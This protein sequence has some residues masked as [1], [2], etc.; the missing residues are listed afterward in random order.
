M[1]SQDARKRGPRD[2]SSEPIRSSSTLG[3]SSASW[4]SLSRRE[5]FLAALSLSASLFVGGGSAK[6]LGAVLPV[7]E[8]A[9]GVFVHH[10]RY[11]EQGPGNQGD[12]ANAAF[13]VG[14]DCVAVIDTLGSFKVGNGL[15]AAVRAVTHR[16]IRYVINT[17]MHPD[18]VFGNAAFKIDNP[19][20]VAH[21]K[22][23]RALSVRADGYLANNR[24]LLGPDVFEGTEIVLP[25]VSV[26]NKL[27]LDLGGRSLVCEAQ[28]TAHTDNDLIVTDSESGTLFLGDLL[29]SEHVPTIDGSILGWL[30]LLDDLATR[31]APR[32]VPGHGPHSMPF[33]QG[34]EPEKRY[35]ET[36]ATDVRQLIRGN[37]TISEAGK[38]AGQSERSKW[39]L[40]S[41]YHVRNVTTAFAEL[42]WE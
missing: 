39:K 34:L 21:H 37:K 23:R 36:V 38:I 2:G 8:V 11:E 28:K 35:L 17:H 3:E 7:L 31:Q 5:A 14:R 16:P 20:F 13:V 30:S 33:P 42:E 41:S 15:R 6:A 4:L 22:L 29:F 26:E 25:T 10:G 19:S 9:S 27:T 1:R 32:V 12:I 40:F 24:E 18:H